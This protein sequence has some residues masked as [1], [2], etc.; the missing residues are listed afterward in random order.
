MPLIAAFADRLYVEELGCQT[1]AVFAYDER[2][3]LL[4]FYLQQLEMES[5]GKSVTADGKPVDQPTA[6][7]TWGGT[8]TDAQHAVFQLLH[9]G[10]VLVPVE[11][12][13][14]REAEDGQ[15]P[16]HHRHAAAQRLRAGRGADAAAGR[17]TIRSAPI[18]ATGRARRSCS[19]G[20]MRARWAR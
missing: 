7:V 17:A 4:P 10:T 3:R 9:Q 16:E 12:V 18:P 15:D 14:V 11:F 1:R 19:T 13:A 20:S 5:N 8:G 6:P 2:L